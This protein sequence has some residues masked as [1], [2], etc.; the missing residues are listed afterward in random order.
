M[1]S[2]NTMSEPSTIS[3]AT[4]G[5]AA[6]D[7]SAGTTTSAPCS[8][9][10]PVSAILRPWLPSLRRDDLRAEMLQHQFGMVAA[11]LLLDHGGDAGRS[12]PRQQ[13]R[14]LDLGRGH[15]GPVR[16]SARD[17][18]RR[19]ASAAGGRLP[20][21]RR[22]WRPSIPGD[23]GSAASGASAARR[24]RRT[25]PRSGSRPPPP[26]PAGSR[27]RNCRNRAERRVGRSRP[28]RR[29]GPA[30]RTGRSGPPWRPAPAWIW[31]Y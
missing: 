17:R 24:R 13:H 10:W 8:S 14:R 29:P 15:R 18:G 28:P 7:G 23:R 6:E 31:P 9:G 4:I 5:N 1:T 2:V 25:P 3:A 11:C 26:S 19:G 16:G 27:C 22:P 30:R 21:P 12:E 20:W